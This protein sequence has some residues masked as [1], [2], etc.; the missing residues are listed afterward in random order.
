MS[1]PSDVIEKRVYIGG[2]ADTVTEQTLSDRF[3]RFGTTTNISVAKDANGN[4]RGFGHLTIKTTAKQWGTCLSAYNGAK[5][6]G[7]IM[8]IEDS[9][10]DYIEKRKIE[11]QLLEQK[12]EKKRKR[13]QRWNDSD[14]FLAKDM[15]PITDRNM[16]TKKG[17]KRG[18]Y[19]R[20]IAVMRLRKD[21]GTQASFVFDPTHYK[22]NLTKFDNLDPVRLRPTHRL[23]MFYEQYP[24]EEQDEFETLAADSSRHNASLDSDVESE[25]ETVDTSAVLKGED[26]RRAA[27]DRR[28]EEQLA[29]KKA[30][31]QQLEALEGKQL[32]T[33]F[34]ASDEEIDEDQ[35]NSR[36]TAPPAAA[37]S[38]DAAVKWMFDSDDDEDQEDD[39]NTDFNIRI[40]PVLEGEK[41]RERLELQSRFKGDERFK[42]GEDFIDEEKPSST[43]NTMDD[44]SKEISAEKD[45]AMDLLKAMF[46][47]QDIVKKYGKKK[48]SICVSFGLIKS[49][50]R[51]TQPAAWSSSARY[52]PDAD[53]ASSYLVDT[54]EETPSNGMGA[55]TD[56]GDEM[57]HEMEEE[58]EDPLEFLKR[59]AE[60]APPEVSKE[61]HFEV[62]VNLKPLFGG[63]AGGF[64]LFGGDD[65]DDD[66]N[67][68]DTQEGNAAL[69]ANWA[70]KNEMANEE[71][72]F[73]P[74]N[75]EPKLGLGLL[76]FFHMED[77]NLMKRSCYGYDPKGIFQQDTE[78]RDSYES[79]WKSRRNQVGEILKR[80]QKS[81]IKKQKRQ[82]SRAIK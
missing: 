63:E 55:A 73:V 44:I 6:K 48:C 60:S 24:N 10:P 18:R 21:D 42:L 50:C 43:Q 36:E 28:V 19:G 25:S 53:N 22:N 17:W 11:Q 67:D 71:P 75:K 57:D 45:Q 20:A 58:E 81:A 1:D 3:N 79:K 38:G 7:H 27:M 46:G 52:D 54:S 34:D 77:P 4:C 8:R 72:S 49:R 82:V 56:V 51:K 5:W 80:R 14:G 69:Q 39:A 12:E 66:D 76:F 30:I 32:H 15:T 29:K 41:G 68:A 9:K 62:N 64:K 61:K 23:P 26:A 78:D 31:Q 74:K 59:P 37:T 13:S 16:P 65:D 2:L 33:K 70:V 40:N 47:E 35:E